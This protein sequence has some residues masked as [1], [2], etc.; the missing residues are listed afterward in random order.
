M[1]SSNFSQIVERTGNG[2]VR[3]KLSPVVTSLK[4]DDVS[5]INNRTNESAISD[6]H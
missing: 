1:K 6:L 4:G 5:S 2:E 3:I